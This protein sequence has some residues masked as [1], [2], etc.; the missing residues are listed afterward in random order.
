[1]KAEARKSGGEQHQSGRFG[2][3]FHERQNRVADERL[4]RRTRVDSVPEQI[5]RRIARGEL[6][7]GVGYIRQSKITGVCHGIAEEAKGIE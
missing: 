6:R 1:M 4:R 7:T 2:D 3:S 5:L